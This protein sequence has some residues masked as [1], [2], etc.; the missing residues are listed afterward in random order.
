MLI[1]SQGSENGSFKSQTQHHFQGILWVKK[2][3]PRASLVQEQG[4][5]PY[6]LMLRNSDMNLQGLEEL[7]VTVLAG[8]LL[9]QIQETDAKWNILLEKGSN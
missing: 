9:V 5:R 4:T 8:N 1:G 7:L 2:K 6:P 3:S